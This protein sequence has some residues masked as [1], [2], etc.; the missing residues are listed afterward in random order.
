MDKEEIL[1]IVGKT[2][3]LMGQYQKAVS[4]MSNATTNQINELNDM[5]HNTEK[6]LK[7]I[8]QKSDATLAKGAYDAVD[9][10][11]NNFQN[12][13]Q[14]ST[15]RMVRESQDLIKLKIELAQKTKILTWKAIVGLVVGIIMVLGVSFKLLWDNHKEYSDLKIAYNK[16]EIA[17]EVKEALQKVEITSCGGEPCLKVDNEAKRWGKNGE[18]ILVK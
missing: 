18:Y 1:N 3:L 15:D 7:H 8:I 9:K 5:V 12:A 2:N 10:S 13:I 6:Q 14:E 17:L 11:L 16:L 4:Q